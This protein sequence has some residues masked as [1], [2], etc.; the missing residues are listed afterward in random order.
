MQ[1]SEMPISPEDSLRVI[2]QTIEN[3]K[4]RVQENGFYLLLWGTL[5]VIAGLWDFYTGW[6]QGDVYHKH[7]AW[8]IMPVVGISATILYEVRRQR[9]AA[10]GGNAFNKLYALTWLGYGITLPM[11]IFYVVQAELSP[12]PP[13]LAVTGFATFMSGQIL[14]FR[15]LT[16]G[17]AAIWAG[18]IV[19]LFAAPLW[20]P[21][22]MAIVTG[23]GYLIPGYLL[24]RSKRN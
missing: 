11:L 18:A 19:T 5:V 2:S 7:Y 6:Q 9:N 12:V 17:A 23:I 24:N 21:L 4:R 10:V 15:P 1:D 22:V 3:A 16:L 20:H 13:I 14:N 8:I